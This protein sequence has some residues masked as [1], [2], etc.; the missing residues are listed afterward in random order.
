MTM[1][2]LFLSR[3]KMIVPIVVV[4][5]LAIIVYAR[6]KLN[7]GGQFD[8][9][10]EDN[11]PVAT[12]TFS[13][14]FQKRNFEEGAQLRVST[15]W[16]PKINIRPGYRLDYS[17]LTEGVKW[18]MLINGEE[19]IERPSI[20]SPEFFDMNRDTR[21]TKFI[22]FRIHPGQSNKIGEMNVLLVPKG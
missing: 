1:K 16:S 20:N 13:G 12:K 19:L 6:Y 8:P 7:I 3:W 11:R 4:T 18:D 2:D 22:Q 9:S 5:S 10:S 15:T 21:M 14:S 17:M